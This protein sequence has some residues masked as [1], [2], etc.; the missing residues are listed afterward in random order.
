MMTAGFIGT[1]IGRRILDR[2]SDQ[3]FALAFRLLLGLLALRLLWQAISG[4]LSA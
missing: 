3:R 2:V 1:L 4:L